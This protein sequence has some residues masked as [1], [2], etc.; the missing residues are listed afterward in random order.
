MRKL[1]AYILTLIF[2]LPSLFNLGVMVDYGVRYQYYAEVLCEN[3]DK[4]AL[5]CNGQCHLVLASESTSDSSPQKLEVRMPE[6]QIISPV[7]EFSLATQFQYTFDHFTPYVE[8][9][10]ES[11]ITSPNKPPEVSEWS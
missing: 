5:Q 2:T 9:A 1:A 8:H 7:A 10:T 6:I 11:R 3:K 4:P